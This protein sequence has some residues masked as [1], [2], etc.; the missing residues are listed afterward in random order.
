MIRTHQGRR[1][2]IDR[3]QVLGER[4][5]G[6]NFLAALMRRNIPGL[7]QSRELGWKHGFA[8]PK[9]AE[10]D[11]LLTLIIYRH[12]VRWLQSVHRT[13]WELDD[14]MHDLAFSDFIRAEWRAVWRNPGPNGAVRVRTNGR[15]LDPETGERFANALRMR[16]T[17]IAWQEGFA[18]RPVNV[19]YLR[20]ET[21]NRA[22]EATMRAIASRFGLSMNDSFEPVTDYKGEGKRSYAPK[23]RP[24]PEPEDLGFIWAELDPSIEA[25]IGYAPD[26]ALSTDGLPIWDRRRWRGRIRRIRS[27][28]GRG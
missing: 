2:P 3:F 8:N 22:P 28:W 18:N 5:S 21:L 24:E 11:G 25:R 17:K 27:F 4:C 19:C 13:P 9:R 6:T 16:R 15:D 14:G 26:A 12:P 23:L 20:Y 7:A 1:A 10:V